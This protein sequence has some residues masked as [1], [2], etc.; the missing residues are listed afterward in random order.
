M[1]EEVKLTEQEKE[2]LLGRLKETI[3]YLNGYDFLMIYQILIDACQREKA[4]M[5]ESIML[6]AVSGE[7]EP[8]KD[9]TVGDRGDRN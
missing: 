7:P 2:T 5:A 6:N 4:A 3:D 8:P 9:D 1:P